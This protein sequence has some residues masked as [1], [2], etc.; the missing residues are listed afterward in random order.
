MS[1]P[2]RSLSSAFN[3][4][5]WG[6]RTLARAAAQMAA[7]LSNGARLRDRL[8]LQTLRVEC[9]VDGIEL[10]DFSAMSSAGPVVAV[11]AINLGTPGLWHSH[12]TNYEPASSGESRVK[13]TR[14][15]RA[16]GSFLVQR[17]GRALKR[18]HT[19]LAGVGINLLGVPVPCLPG[20]PGYFG[21]FEP[22]EGH[23][24]ILGGHRRVS[25][26]YRD[27]ASVGV[28]MFPAGGAAGPANHAVCH[29]E[30]NATLPAVLSSQAPVTV[31]AGMRRYETLAALVREYGPQLVGML[32]EWG[33]GKIVDAL[34]GAVLARVPILGTLMSR[35]LVRRVLGPVV[36]NWIRDRVREA[37]VDWVAEQAAEALGQALDPLLRDAGGVQDNQSTEEGLEDAF[38]RWM[39]QR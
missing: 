2:Q 24:D 19:L 10:H 28:M 6:L 35:L 17:Y 27:V 20:T 3:G 37:V 39:E 38:N 13:H 9:R 31:F 11:T 30:D 22:A 15:V 29:G 26:R 12:G 14:M 32:L 18:Q 1:P 4:L 23:C 36:R 16:C 25:S 34:L 8:R 7:E 5:S 21:F 33:I